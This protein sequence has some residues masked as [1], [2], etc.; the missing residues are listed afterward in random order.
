MPRGDWTSGK[1]L[2]G[3]TRREQRH[4]HAIA[5]RPICHDCTRKLANLLLALVDE[6]RDAAPEVI[7]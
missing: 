6:V 3:G 1:P 7:R 4:E 5:R 2:L